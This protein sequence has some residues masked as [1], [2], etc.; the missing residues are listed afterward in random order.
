MYDLPVKCQSVSPSVQW[1]MHRPCLRWPHLRSAK[2]KKK[3]VPP[4]SRGPRLRSA[5]PSQSG[6]EAWTRFAPNAPSSKQAGALRKQASERQVIAS[7]GCNSRIDEIGYR[8]Y[9]MHGPPTAVDGCC[10]VCCIS[11]HD[12]RQ[13]RQEI[14][15]GALKSKA[16]RDSGNGCTGV[17][18]VDANIGQTRIL[19]PDSLAMPQR[20]SLMH[21]YDA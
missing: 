9:S 18:N 6:S 17:V 2:K 1:L 12:E 4:S 8:Y 11:N 16:A 19:D 14:V 3:S 13:D 10:N 20:S 5:R 15:S 7:T 21:T